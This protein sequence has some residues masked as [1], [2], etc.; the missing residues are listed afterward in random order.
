MRMM[1]LLKNF[2]MAELMMSVNEC[3]IICKNMPYT[4]V[5]GQTTNPRM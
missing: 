1:P 3:G 5:A 4:M 2:Y